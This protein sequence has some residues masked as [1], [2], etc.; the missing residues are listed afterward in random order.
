MK[1]FKFVA[2]ICCLVFMALATTQ[3][4]KAQ[5]SNEKSILT[6]S[7]PFEVPGV[8]AQ[9]LP[10][11][12]YAFTLVDSL[13]DRNI[14][15]ITNVDGTHVYTTI[16]AIANYRLKP[17]EKTVLTFK[18]RGEGQPEAIKAWFYPGYAW[19][20]EFVY[21]KKRAIELAKIV[22]EPVLAMPVEVTTTHVEVLKNVQLEAIK[23]T[24]EEVPVT[25]VVETPPAVVAQAQPQT[26]PHTASSLPLYVLVGLLSLCAGFTL[27]IITKRTA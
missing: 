7:E 17:T 11:G 16:L 21:P 15:R 23:P 22:D 18:E 14:V 2:I 20:Q 6:F 5:T 12:T 13:S 24:G 8:G 3:R 1:R 27:L 9:I 25:A 19:G 4:V 26:L 10:A